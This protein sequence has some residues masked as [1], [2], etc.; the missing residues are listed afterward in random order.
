MYDTKARLLKDKKVSEDMATKRI[1][2]MME[3]LFPDKKCLKQE[4]IIDYRQ[5]SNRQQ[6]M[7]MTFFPERFNNEKEYIAVSDFYVCIYKRKKDNKDNNLNNKFRIG[8]FRIENSLN[9]CIY[10]KAKQFNVLEVNCSDDIINKG[11]VSG[12]YMIYNVAS[13]EQIRCSLREGMAIGDYIPGYATI[14]EINEVLFNVQV[15]YTMGA[16]SMENL[17]Y[18]SRKGR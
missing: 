13:F 3:T 8:I 1:K 11:I 17:F 18:I 2:D 6:A 16:I 15:Y 7:M 12:N 10:R 5:A 9:G 4:T 14:E